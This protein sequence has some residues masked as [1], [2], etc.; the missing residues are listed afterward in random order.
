MNINTCLVSPGVT[1]PKEKRIMT[2]LRKSKGAKTKA[3]TVG[4]IEARAAIA[5]VKERAA[6]GNEADQRLLIRCYLEQHV[7]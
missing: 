5:A 1:H 6:E 4:V 3:P 7:H 2:E